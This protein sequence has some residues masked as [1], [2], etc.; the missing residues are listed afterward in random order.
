MVLMQF[1]LVRSVGTGLLASAGLAGLVLGLAAQQTL[2]NIFAGIQLAVTQ[3]VRIDDIVVFEGEF[4]TVEEISLSHVVLRTWDLRR[5]VVPIPYLLAHPLQNWTRHSPELLG[6]VF[7]RA[8]YTVDVQAARGEA[9]RVATASQWW[10]RKVQ[11]ELLVTDLGDRTVEL[12]VMVSAADAGQLWKLRCE[13]REAMLRWL[14]AA[15][16]TP[17]VRLSG[18]AGPEAPEAAR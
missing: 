5:L 17:R 18:E 1:E 4:S 15:G 14:Q 2:S 3:P 13:V 9:V 12:R 16:A 11:P 6:T 8:D 10:D 7:L